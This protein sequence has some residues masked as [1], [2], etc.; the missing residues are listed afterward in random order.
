MGETELAH[1]DPQQL[2]FLGRVD[3]LVAL[4]EAGGWPR[5]LL[6]EAALAAFAAGRDETC[7]ELA[8]KDRAVWAIV[9]PLLVA[10]GAHTGEVRA[11]L[12]PGASALRRLARGV[13]AATKGE[14]V[15]LRGGAAIPRHFQPDMFR[16][17]FRA[18][19]GSAS[20]ADIEELAGRVPGD[21]LV[22]ELSTTSSASALFSASRALTGGASIA[23]RHAAL[24]RVEAVDQLAELLR[25]NPS[26]QSGA[27]DTLRTRLLAAFG[28]TR[29][30]PRTARELFDELAKEAP[31]NCEVL[32]GRLLSTLT[33][34]RQMPLGGVELARR[35][36]ADLL[37]LDVAL[38]KQSA[39][40]M[41][42]IAAHLAAARQLMALARRGYEELFDSASATAARCLEDP[43]L[44]AALPDLVRV[45]LELITSTAELP[46][47]GLE[48]CDAISQRKLEL[49]PALLEL[50]WTTRVSCA[51][52]LRSPE[53]A[54]WLT[55]ALDV[56]E[57]RNARRMLL[58]VRTARLN[59]SPLEGG[60]S[61][62]ALEFAFRLATAVQAREPV[63][64]L[65]LGLTVLEAASKRWPALD[66]AI[67]ELV[68][69]DVAD[70]LMA[71]VPEQT[72]PALDAWLRGVASSGRN[73]ELPLLAIQKEDSIEVV[74]HLLARSIEI[75]CTHPR[76]VRSLVRACR[77][78]WSRAELERWIGSNASRLPRDTLRAVQGELMLASAEP[79]AA[80]AK[81]D[82][83]VGE[84]VPGMV[85]AD[86]LAEL[87][88]AY[89]PPPSA[90]DPRD[91][92]Q[93][94]LEL[95]PWMMEKL[96]PEAIT[97]LVRITS[98]PPSPEGL[99]AI[100]CVLLDNG[101]RQHEYARLAAKH[102]KQSE[103]PKKYHKKTKQARK[104][105]RQNRKKNR[106]K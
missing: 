25:V 14:A 104:Q 55:K 35:A 44:R 7:A 97:T 60:E 32:R 48:R 19:G 29:A 69:L 37:D 65:R 83:R 17:A 22:G 30:D 39:D 103:L 84:L 82:Q 1:E 106:R 96:T 78:R 94:V 59:T 26:W 3:E 33:E 74:E 71:E 87:D 80:F 15:S 79:W 95:D 34:L 81:L 5:P 90:P 46:A 2:R 101:I 10:S 43:Q 68:W 42:R 67:A 105:Q 8:R 45:E 23:A 72:L 88:D 27:A 58:R 40:A 52:E 20:A 66:V 38:Q 6:L 63:G 31:E 99:I 91:A 21:V 57:R 53:L 36:V 24:N 9:A 85:L 89:E 93:E 49:P 100:G 56:V 62:D 75:G 41:D 73:V 12:S 64:E 86:V 102:I 51:E 13:A 4:A 77:A 16:A 54:E 98:A 61:A 92:L 28:T 76:V 70:S 50:F 47:R 11:K 18:A